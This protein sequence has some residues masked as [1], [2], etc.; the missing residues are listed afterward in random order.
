MSTYWLESGLAGRLA[1]AARPRGGEWLPDEIRNWKTS[2][3]DIVVSLLEANEANE[4]DLA[5][6]ESACIRQGLD[7][8]SLPIPDRGIPDNRSAVLR[9]VDRLVEALQQGRNVVIHCRQGIGRSAT[10]TAVVLAALG[11]PPDEAFDR[12]TQVRGRDV[13]DTDQQR[14]WVL[15]LFPY[16]HQMP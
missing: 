6:E 14:N 11:L 1:I 16:R 13:P 2:G 4:L 15:G 8:H 10:V 3:V 7:Y 9:L 5:D 12:I